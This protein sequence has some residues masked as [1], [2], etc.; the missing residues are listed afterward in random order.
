MISSSVVTLVE[1][2]SRKVNNGLL[3]SLTSFRGSLSGFQAR[4]ADDA[5]VLL[6]ALPHATAPPGSSSPK[7]VAKHSLYIPPHFVHPKATL[8]NGM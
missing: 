5:R 3:A 2:N 4:A 8:Q 6:A 1:R 7:V